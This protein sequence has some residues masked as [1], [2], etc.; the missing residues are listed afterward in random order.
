[1]RFEPTGEVPVV[2]CDIRSPKQV[3]HQNT[4]VYPFLSDWKGYVLSVIE[5]EAVFVKSGAVFVA[6][7]LTLEK[8]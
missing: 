7:Q 3:C 2:T 5:S 6:L 4:L 8:I 1:M